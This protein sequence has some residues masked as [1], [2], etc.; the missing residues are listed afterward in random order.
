MVKIPYPVV[1]NYVKET[2]KKNI[3]DNDKLKD[4]DKQKVLL[5]KWRL[6]NVIKDK[7][8]LLTDED[9]KK[10]WDLFIKKNQIDINKDLF[11]KISYE[12][13]SVRII[14]QKFNKHIY[15]KCPIL[16][17]EEKT[18]ALKLDSCDKVKWWARNVEKKPSAFYL[19]GYLSG[20]FYPDF[21]VKTTDDRFYL[22]EYKGKQLNNEETKYKNKIGEVWEKLNS[23]KIYF[24]LVFK[25]KIQEFID[26]INK[27]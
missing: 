26:E 2:I 1:Y 23:K 11:S 5:N 25:D 19:H 22:A 21:I 16:N 13:L 15:D 6:V 8:K 7:I 10:E 17:G 12:I 27:K 20:K 4:E 9:S 24:R 18:F 14:D 3:L